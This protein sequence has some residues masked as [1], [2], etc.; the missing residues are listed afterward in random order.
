MDPAS[1]AKMRGMTRLLAY[2]LAGCL[3]A[4]AVAPAAGAKTLFG[5]VHPH[6]G[7]PNAGGTASQPEAS[8]EA[9][10]NSHRLGVDVLELDVKLTIDNVAVVH[11]DATFDR[12]TNC[13]GQVRAKSAAE[14]AACRI[15]TLGTATLMRPADGPGVA[16]PT[17]AE[18]L[19]FA[20]SERIPLNLEIKNQP[21]DPDFDGTPGFARTVLGAIEA[22][23]IPNS[24]VL[25]QSF[26]PPNLDE[27]KAAGFQTSLLT[28]A[29]LNRQGI[30]VARDGGYN[31]LS[32]GWPIDESYMQEARAAGKAVIPYTLDSREDLERAVGLGVDGLISNDPELAIRVVYGAACDRAKAQRKRA[33]KKYRRAKRRGS[34]AARRKARR[35]LQRAKR[36]QRTT[37]ARLEP[38][39]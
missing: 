35:S 8:M 16:I 29:Q 27:A 7:G 5:G 4:L 17:L 15:D 2:G 13:E 22:S 1:L 23:G 6:R 9:F 32:P 38:L 37:C 20:R 34:P 21:T 26:W 3:V 36:R 33:A 19:E 14:V 28:L 18:L 11:H 25:I 30:Q 10:R 24:M 12:T 39:G 31:V